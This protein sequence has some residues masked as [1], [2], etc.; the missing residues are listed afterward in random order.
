MLGGKPWSHESKVL[1][2]TNVTVGKNHGEEY[3]A[4]EDIA[5]EARIG[6]DGVLQEVHQDRETGRQE[7]PYRHKWRSLPRGSA[8]PD[9]DPIAIGARRTGRGVLGAATWASGRGGPLRYL[10]W[11]QW[12]PQDRLPP[13]GSRLSCG[14]RAH[15]R[16]AME[17]KRRLGGEA[18]QLFLTRDRPP[19]SSAC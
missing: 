19:A 13:N 15:G 16:K 12:W 11:K 8:R 3:A 5:A 6:S 18:T 14:R 4:G 1:C 9:W 17:Q 2:P 7:D 10:R